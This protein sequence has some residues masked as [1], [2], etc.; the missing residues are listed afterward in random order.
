M[1]STCTILHTYIRFSFITHNIG[2]TRALHFEKITSLMLTILQ[3]KINA[4]NSY[5]FHVLCYDNTNLQWFIKEVSLF[6]PFSWSVFVF[7][8]PLHV[9]DPAVLIPCPDTHSVP[10]I[11]IILLFFFKIKPIFFLLYQRVKMIIRYLKLLD[12]MRGFRVSIGPQH[13]CLS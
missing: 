8:S 1:H 9:S 4:Q 11:S 12:L 2:P 6:V 13:P 5:Y 10:K 3:R 7:Q